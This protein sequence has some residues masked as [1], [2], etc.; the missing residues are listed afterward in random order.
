MAGRSHAWKTSYEHWAL[1]SE[2]QVTSW[3]YETLLAQAMDRHVSPDWTVYR[4]QLEAK[5]T[6]LDIVV[7][8]NLVALEADEPTARPSK[9]RHG[10]TRENMVPEYMVPA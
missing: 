8:E 5:L 7:L 10:A 9:A 2:F 6:W 3:A 4:V 1:I